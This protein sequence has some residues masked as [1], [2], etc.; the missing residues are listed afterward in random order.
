[1][2]DGDSIGRIARP[3]FHDE[4]AFTRLFAGILAHNPQRNRYTRREGG[5]S[6]SHG[7][8]SP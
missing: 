8:I 6:V 7:A 5:N 1:M 4:A 2:L 3:W